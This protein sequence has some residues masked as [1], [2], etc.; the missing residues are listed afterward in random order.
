MHKRI[1]LQKETCLM[2]YNQFGNVMMRGRAAA[3]VLLGLALAF[4][5]GP[6]NLPQLARNL[7][8]TSC[9]R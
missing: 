2:L 4:A 7:E 6:F 5:F 3:V 9:I 1:A 8:S